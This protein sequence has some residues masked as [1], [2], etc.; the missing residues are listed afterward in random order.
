MRPVTIGRKKLDTRVKRAGRTEDRSDSSVVEAAAIKSF[1]IRDYNVWPR[2]FS[3]ADRPI[4]RL[5]GL[6]SAAWIAQHS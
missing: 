4:Q 5:P 1:S 3:L 6:T 2:G